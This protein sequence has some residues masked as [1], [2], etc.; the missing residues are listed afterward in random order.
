[1][2][3][4]GNILQRILFQHSTVYKFNTNTSMDAL[5]WCTGKGGLQRSFIVFIELYSFPHQ[6]TNRFYHGIS[7]IGMGILA[8]NREIR[9]I[10]Q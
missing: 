3:F 8:L 10:S 2:E 9:Q 5:H 4:I 7:D 6:N 1:M